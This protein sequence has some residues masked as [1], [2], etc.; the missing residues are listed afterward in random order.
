MLVLRPRPAKPGV[1]KSSVISLLS[2]FIVYTRGLE[3][4]LLTVLAL[5]L[6]SAAPCCCCPLPLLL[7]HPLFSLCWPQVTFDP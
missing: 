2:C 6:L 1:C 5:L 3:L 4:N 7:L